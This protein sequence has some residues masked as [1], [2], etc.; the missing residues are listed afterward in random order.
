MPKVLTPLSQ[1]PHVHGL[2]TAAD[3]RK[4]RTLGARIFAQLLPW[5]TTRIA[6][7]PPSRHS[8]LPSACT[9]PANP[10]AL[11]SGAGVGLSMSGRQQ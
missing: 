8:S 11:T 2:S 4:V 7:L 6:T 10:P 5:G 9:S 1:S 3:A